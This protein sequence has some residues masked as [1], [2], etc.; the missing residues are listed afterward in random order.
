MSYYVTLTSFYND[1][2]ICVKAYFM[3]GVS[4]EGKYYILSIKY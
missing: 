1:V 2:K 3:Y 4:H